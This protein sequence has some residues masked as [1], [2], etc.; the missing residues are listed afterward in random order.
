MPFTEARRHGNYPISFFEVRETVEELG[1]AVN[2]IVNTGLF[3]VRPYSPVLFT[4]ACI[5]GSHFPASLLP[6][7]LS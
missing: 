1:G 3:L 6:V 7:L 2:E 5:S 4:Y